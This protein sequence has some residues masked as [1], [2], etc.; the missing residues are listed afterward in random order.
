MQ[1]EEERE[2]ARLKRQVRETNRKIDRILIDLASP[3]FHL[4]KAEGQMGAMLNRPYK[5]PAIFKEY[6]HLAENYRRGWIDGYEIAIEHGY[7]PTI[8]LPKSPLVTQ[9]EES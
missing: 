4:G 2:L 5:P 6:L 7:K 3:A 9:A 8:R 1:T